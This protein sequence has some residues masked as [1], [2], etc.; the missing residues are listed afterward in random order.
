[1]QRV[2]HA[3]AA[4]N[5]FTLFPEKGYESVTLSCI[6]NTKGME[7]SKLNKELSKR[8]HAIISN[9]YGDIQRAAGE[10]CPA[11]RAQDHSSGQVGVDGS[12]GEFNLV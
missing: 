2:V 9:G 5:G 1:M 11:G 7:I 8:H 4:K 6:N 12:A 10:F 3:W